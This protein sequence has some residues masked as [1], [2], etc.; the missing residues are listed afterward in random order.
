MKKTFVIFS[1]V[2]MFGLLVSSCSTPKELHAKFVGVERV[3][4]VPMGSSYEEVVRYFGSSPYEMMSRQLD[5]Y[6]VFVWKYRVVNREVTAKEYD[7]KGGES[8]GNE[9][10]VGELKNV[11][12]LFK[13]DRLMDLITVD[14]SVATPELLLITNTIY[15]VTKDAKGYSVEDLN[16]LKPEDLEY[17]KSMKSKEK[18]PV[19]VPDKKSKF[20]F[21]K[22]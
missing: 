15:Q 14:G 3:M 10:Y 22:F 21:F 1:I 20:P 9:K 18:G 16:Y 17:L 7:S 13:N 6:Q 19:A 12:A 11:Y 4:T 8:N 5:G 2:A